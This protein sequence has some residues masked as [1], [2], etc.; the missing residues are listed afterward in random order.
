M[1]D[2]SHRVL[3]AALPALL[4]NDSFH[5]SGFFVMTQI[6]AGTGKATAAAMRAARTSESGY[7]P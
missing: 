7:G 5:L 2:A 3:M 4:L 1:C 6:D